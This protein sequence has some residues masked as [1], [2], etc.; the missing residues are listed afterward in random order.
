[1][2]ERAWS[3]EVE[4]VEGS[5]HIQTDHVDM[6]GEYCLLLQLF[7]QT[8][9][10]QLCQDHHLSF[11]GGSNELQQVGM[12]YSGGHVHLSFEQSDVVRRDNLV[13]NEFCSHL[14][15][16]EGGNRDSGPTPSP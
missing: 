6:L 13:M 8:G 3:H 16:P 10:H 12:A 2:N 7:P 11:Q 9:G 1:M 5:G 4:V 14:S 15:S